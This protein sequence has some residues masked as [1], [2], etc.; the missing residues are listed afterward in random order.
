MCRICWILTLLLAIAAGTLA[1]KFILR[2]ETVPASDGRTAILLSE[3]ERDLV[4]SEM[5]AFLAA[6]QQ[7]L[8]AAVRNDVDGVADAAR[9]VGMATR[10]EVP[11]SLVGKLPLA[12]KKLGFATHQAFDQLALDT[13]A[14]GDTR[15]VPEEVAGLMA[16]CVG[17]HATYRLQVAE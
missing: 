7:I 3:G 5:R 6:V 12:F 4:L 11:D 8:D 9:A 14:L 16:N 2:G 17:C 15:E 1:W 10:A 13:Q